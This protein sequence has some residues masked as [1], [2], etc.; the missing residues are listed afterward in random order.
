MMSRNSYLTL[1]GKDWCAPVLDNPAKLLISSNPGRPGALR[2]KAEIIIAFVGLVFIDIVLKIIGFRTFYNV[3]KRWP[4][5]RRRP[6]DHSQI[7]RICSAVDRA[8]NFYFK[9]AWCL[10]RSAVGVCLLRLRGFPAELVIGA[11][12]TPFYAHAWVEMNGKVLNDDEET[13]R[14][15][16][17]VLER[18]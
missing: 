2:Q 8:A 16:F 9:H 3:M 17:A 10:Q 15:L 14:S 11:R 6:Q 5:L 12:K 4:T 1:S 7:W 13:I 18:C